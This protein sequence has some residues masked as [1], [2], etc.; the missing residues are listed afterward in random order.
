M[1]KRGHVVGGGG[2]RSRCATSGGVKCKWVG[3]WRVGGCFL[4][5]QQMAEELPQ[6]PQGGG[7]VDQGLGGGV[8]VD[9]GLGG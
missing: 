3:F 6:P 4:D 9:Q 8:G 2:L 1:G 7:G 5:T